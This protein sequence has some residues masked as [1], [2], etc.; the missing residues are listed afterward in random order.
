MSHKSKLMTK[1][2]LFLIILIFIFYEALVWLGS[3]L[4]LADLGFLVGFVLTAC[5]LTVLLVYVLVARMAGAA[6]APTPG[7]VPEAAAPVP[8]PASAGLSPVSALIQEANEQL[9]KSS[10]L[11]SQR[12]KSTITDFPLYL[13]LRSEERRVG[14][15]G[16]AR[17][18]P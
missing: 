17:R 16:R 11:A 2:K 1:R 7:S 4:L 13:V 15:A 5:G 3:L 8:S 6:Q 18:V 14:K 10:T 12:V 9:S